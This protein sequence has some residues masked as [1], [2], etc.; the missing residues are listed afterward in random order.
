MPGLIILGTRPEAIK[1]IPVI[2]A[3]KILQMPFEILSTEQHYE[4]VHQIFDENDISIDLKLMKNFNPALSTQ[5]AYY[6]SEFDIFLNKIKYDYVIAQGDTLSA[7]AGMLYAYLNKIDFLYI[8]SGLRTNDLFNPYP[9]EGLR[10]MMSHIAKINFVPT[11]KEKDY[12]IK[13]N[14]DSSKIMVV[15]NTGIDYI[16]SFVKNNQFECQ[17]NKILMTVHRRE[18]WEYLDNFFS[19]IATFAKENSHIK[20]IYPMHFNPD[21]QVLANKYFLNIENI[22]LLKPLRSE[23]FY[24]YLL[25]SDLVITDSGGVQEEASFLNKKI[26]VI[27]DKTERNYQEQII[28]NISIND[29]KLFSIIDD[30]LKIEIKNHGLNY[31]YGDGNSADRIASWIKKEYTK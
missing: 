19:K 3:L 20:I 26:I 4:A 23:E 31:Y 13:E 15:G 22:T 8:E 28:R 7:Y 1:L 2:K 24:S 10:V 6:L 5:L 11:T 25:T 29:N 30:L 27:R 9:E 16:S 18:N 12:L 17:K 14:I 21:I